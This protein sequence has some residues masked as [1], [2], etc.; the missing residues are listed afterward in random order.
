MDYIIKKDNEM[1]HFFYQKDKGLMMSGRQ[2]AYLPEQI[3]ENST[4]KFCAYGNDEGVH[5]IC[6]STGNELVY[7]LVQG[8]KAK[9]YVM[10]ELKE[11]L[12]VREI[13]LA[14]SKNMLN[15]FYSAE[16]EKE[17]LLVHCVLGNHARPSV[18]DK[19]KNGNFFTFG[20][21]VYYT[22]LSG[23][24]GYQEFTDGKPD[25]FIHIADGAEDAYLC[26]DGEKEYMTYRR[27]S[28]IYINH[29]PKLDD[30]DV[31]APIIA[32]RS[33][34]LILMWKSGAIVKY[35]DLETSAP[36]KKMLSTGEQSPCCV[37]EGT[38]IFYDYSMPGKN[39]EIESKKSEIKEIINSIF[40]IKNEI[41]E[42]EE[43]IR[44][45]DKISDFPVDLDK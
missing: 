12:S 17:T 10:C 29:I 3:F 27:G 14:E 45:I 18:I 44:R 36:A 30:I 40:G 1:L 23:I 11:D 19:I 37:Q 34:R 28:T 38:D 42:I 26:S 22:N 15:L 33:N 2:G 5:I 6:V 32:K 43:K 39:Y 9:E 4:E 7:I 24:L 41:K 8:T 16:Y 13:S 31:K 21:R 25:R 20:G 35:T